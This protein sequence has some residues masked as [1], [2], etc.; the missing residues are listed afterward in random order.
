[1]LNKTRNQLALS[2][3]SKVDS[4]QLSTTTWS[5]PESI[6]ASLC[7]NWSQGNH[8]LEVQQGHTRNG[9]WEN[10]R[11]N[12][13]HLVLKH[14]KTKVSQVDFPIKQSANWWAMVDSNS[15][16]VTVSQRRFCKLPMPW[17]CETHVKKKGVNKNKCW[18]WFTVP[19]PVDF[20]WGN[21]YDK[22]RKCI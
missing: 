21:A 14:V 3:K 13:L 18:L 17:Q 22:S 10:L 15:K 12:P 20:A 9:E 4:M 7:T 8:P 5:C 19:L 2:A 11:W 1:M 6:V 16:L